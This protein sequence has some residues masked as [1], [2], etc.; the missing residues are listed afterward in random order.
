LDQPDGFDIEVEMISL[1]CEE[2]LDIE[3][4]VIGSSGPKLN[5]PKTEKNPIEQINLNG[6]I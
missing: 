3:S 5:E 4:V 6:L 1:M 2:H